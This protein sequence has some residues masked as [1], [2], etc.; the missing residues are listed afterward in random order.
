MKLFFQLW[1]PCKNPH[2]QYKGILGISTGN[3]LSLSSHFDCLPLLW[4]FCSR[5]TVHSSICPKGANIIRTSFSLHFLDSIPINSFLSSTTGTQ[6]QPFWYRTKCQI[7]IYTSMYMICGQNI[8]T[9]SHTLLNFSN[10]Q[11]NTFIWKC[12]SFNNSF[13]FFIKKRPLASPVSVK[14]I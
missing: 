14:Y 11:S 13:H 5:R 4:P 9:T 6:K 7:E 8:N 12:L 3:T 2:Y 10:K 1:R